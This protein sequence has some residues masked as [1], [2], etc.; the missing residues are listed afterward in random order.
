MKKLI[1]TVFL[2][3]ATIHC[4]QAL[5]LPSILVHPL[6]A[7]TGALAALGAQDIVRENGSKSLGRTVAGA[8]TGSA[9]YYLSYKFFYGITA[10][11]K[12]KRANDVAERIAADNLISER[13]PS[14]DAVRAQARKRYFGSNWP[15]VEAHEDLVQAL[16]DI[17]HARGLA[18]DARGHSGDNVAFARNCDK[19][20]AMLSASSDKVALRIEEMIGDGEEYD[21]QYR[22]FQKWREIQLQEE[23]VALQ[24]YAITS[25]Q[26]N[27]W[28]NMSTDRRQHYDFMGVLAKKVLKK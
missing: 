6:S 1:T 20:L 19:L 5:T 12:F 9:I 15:L 10:K 28:D 7:T 27:H 24:S 2:L 22:R 26:F 14:P 13:Y 4:T 16:R 3:L 11:G 25:D 8:L 18:T 21:R 17:S 23:S